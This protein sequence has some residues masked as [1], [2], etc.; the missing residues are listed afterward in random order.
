[1][2]NLPGIRCPFRK[3]D[4]FLSFALFC[5]SVSPRQWVSSLIEVIFPLSEQTG[6]GLDGGDGVSG[7]VAEGTDDRWRP[8]Y[9]GGGRS[10]KEEHVKDLLIGA[11]HLVPVR[12]G[13]I[14]WTS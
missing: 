11:I 7:P 10:V 5:I 3:G 13:I 8:L 14:T 2:L 4:N 1:M 12:G 6:G 9:W